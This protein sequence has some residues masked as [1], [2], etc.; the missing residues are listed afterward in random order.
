MVAVEVTGTIK[1]R[2]SMCIYSINAVA[3]AAEVARLLQ[4]GIVAA[5]LFADREDVAAGIHQ[6]HQRRRVAVP[7]L[8]AVDVG[9]V[10]A[11]SHPAVVAG[12]TVVVVAHKAIAVVYTA[13]RTAVAAVR[14]TRS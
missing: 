1:G 3:Y 6:H 13:G 12:R 7:G 11:C 10:E 9:E 2:R 14:R 4:Q 8:V 5:C